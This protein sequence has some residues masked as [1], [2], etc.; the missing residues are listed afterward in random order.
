MITW[1]TIV[2]WVLCYPMFHPRTTWHLM[3]LTWKEI[4][5]W[6]KIC[7]KKRRAKIYRSAE[8]VDEENRKRR[9]RYAKNKEIRD[10]Q[11]ANMTKRSQRNQR[12]KWRDSKQL[13]KERKALSSITNNISVHQVAS[14]KK[15]KSRN[16][17]KCYY[18]NK[19]L[20]QL[21]EKLNRTVQKYRTRLS[22]L[23]TKYE[24]S[25]TSPKSTVMKY[26]KRK[27]ENIDPETVQ[28]RRMIGK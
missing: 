4:L 1:K 15:R 18:R 28:R 22:R 6:K 16:I 23:Q 13:Q 20:E 25:A 19:V 26:L 3:A 21:N 14:D 24:N 17:A 2:L 12:R 5:L 10:K 27:K 9:E 7:E 11:K 8:L